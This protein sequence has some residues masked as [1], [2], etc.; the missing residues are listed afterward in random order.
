MQEEKKKIRH[1]YKTALQK[2]EAYCAYQERCQQEVRDKLYDLG[3]YSDEVES[4][5]AELISN[6]FINEERFAKAFAGGKFRIKKW[7]RVKIK[8]ELKFRKLS[9]YCIR[10]GLL[11]IDE[12][13]YIKTL[14]HL[15]L[16]KEKEIK[17]KLGPQKLFKIHR[18]VVS[19]G[20]EQDLIW[21]V[22]NRIVKEG[23]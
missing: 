9:E 8:Q 4:A 19:R 18:Y 14:E 15:I 3:L 1:D 2:A 13:E 7:G 20:F 21:D 6:N 22:L 10:K 12:L 5:I 11:E 16:K 23:S 17:G